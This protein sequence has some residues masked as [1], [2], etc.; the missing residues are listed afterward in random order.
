MRHFNNLVKIEQAIERICIFSQH[1]TY[2]LRKKINLNLVVFE[3]V[4]T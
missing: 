1:A 3:N 2:F 4:K